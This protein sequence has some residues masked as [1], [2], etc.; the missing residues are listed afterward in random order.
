MPFTSLSGNAG[1]SVG[2]YRT[3]NVDTPNDGVQAVIYADSGQAKATLEWS[4]DG[5][6]STNE[7]ATA[8]GYYMIGL[9]YMI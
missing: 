9:T 3:Y 1:L 8:N 4:R 5:T 7:R 6:Q 2:N